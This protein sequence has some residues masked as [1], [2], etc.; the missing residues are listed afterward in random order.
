MKRT[1]PPVQNWIRM[2][3]WASIRS[4]FIWVYEGTVEEKY[5]SVRVHYP[6]CSALLI[7]SG[8]LRVE[9]E[10]GETSAGKGHWVF[11]R[12]G[13][14]LQE[15]SGEARVLSL[16]FNFQWP[17]GMPVFA[18]D[19]AY[20][21]E[22]AAV[23]RLEKEA[24]AMLGIAKRNFPG[25]GSAMPWTYGDIQTQLLLNKGLA[26]WLCIY[27]QTLLNAGMLPSRLG[28]I[29]D[30]VARAMRVIDE[31]P[32]DGKFDKR[33]LAAEVGLSTGQ[34]DR[35]FA[36][37]FGATPRQHVD[38]RKLDRCMELMQN[39]ALSIK[40]IGGELGFQSQPFFCRWFRSHTGNSP[41]QYLKSHRL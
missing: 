9:T 16:H 2:A 24:R 8:T 40:E 38:R 6:G 37:Q 26:N 3:D 21:C 29:D 39:S 15:F 14:R 23:P 7:L 31:L 19:V 13:P 10:H 18:W 28:P 4:E 11:P 41:R 17:G 12:Q 30:R 22:S 20:V 5:R 35:L 36:K 1:S 33:G 34:L 27:V 32:L 25:A